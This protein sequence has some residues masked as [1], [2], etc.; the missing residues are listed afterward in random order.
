MIL[1]ALGKTLEELKNMF[2]DTGSI[3]NLEV[4]RN[5]DI[6]NLNLK[7]IQSKFENV[8]IDKFYDNKIQELNVILNAVT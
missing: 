5:G 3:Y 7:Y 1:I 2:M 8:T 4:E 6:Y